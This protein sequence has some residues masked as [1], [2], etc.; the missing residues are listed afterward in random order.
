M[1]T[2]KYNINKNNSKTIKNSK[3]KN[4]KNIKNSKHRTHKHKKNKK[5]INNSKNS[6]KTL[7]IIGG[8]GTV[9]SANDIKITYKSGLFSDI[10][11]TTTYPTLRDPNFKKINIKYLKKNI[12]NITITKYGTYKF[13]LYVCSHESQ[14]PLTEYIP[15]SNPNPTDSRYRNIDKNMSTTNKIIRFLT[16]HKTRGFFNKTTY[17]FETSNAYTDFLATYNRFI[18]IIYCFT[19]NN[20][21]HFCKFY[22]AIEKTN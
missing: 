9:V 14:E 8:D 11:S 2:L 4:N 3:H 13:V 1:K 18:I 21:R 22:F 20:P 17:N 16:I 6:I 7:L 5:N 19:V 15:T 10:E 12:P